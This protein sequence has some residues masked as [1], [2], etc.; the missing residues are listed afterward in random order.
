VEFDWRNE[1]PEGASESIAAHVILNLRLQFFPSSSGI[2]REDPD[3]PRPSFSRA[4][5]FAV[6]LDSRRFCERARAAITAARTLSFTSGNILP[7]S[8]S[9]QISI[10]GASIFAE[11]RRKR[12]L[13]YRHF[14]ARRRVHRLT[15]APRKAP[16]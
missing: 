2:P 8:L 15:S 11:S 7:I 16:C 10:R 5:R 4:P 1:R 9:M 14:I 13:M 6:L 12:I 3:S